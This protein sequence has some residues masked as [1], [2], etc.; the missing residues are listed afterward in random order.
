MFRAIRFL[1]ELACI[2]FEFVFPEHSFLPQRSHD[3]VLLAA[4]RARQ[5][6]QLYSCQLMADAVIAIE[7]EPFSF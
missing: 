7:G 4:S 2:C 3:G 6:F 1:I 5:I